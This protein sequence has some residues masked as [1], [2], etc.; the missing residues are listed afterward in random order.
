[1]GELKYKEQSTI[2][3]QLNE[4]FGNCLFPGIYFFYD[5]GHYYVPSI[6]EIEAEFEKYQSTHPQMH[7]NYNMIYNK[8]SEGSDYGVFQISVSHELGHETT[9]IYEIF[10][11]K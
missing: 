4:S 2:V 3:F 1:L 5:N 9:E 8:S 6:T 11:D 7:E 10:S